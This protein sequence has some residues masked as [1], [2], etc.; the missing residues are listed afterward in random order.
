MK[1]HTELLKLRTK[2]K[3]ITSEILEKLQLME[4]KRRYLVL[5]YSSLFDYLVRG[6]GY[7]GST[8]YERQSCL[9]LSREIPEIKEK[10]Q[11][12][13]LTYS[14]VTAAY[15]TLKKKSTTE[16]KVI[17]QRLENKSVREVKRLLA[18]PAKPIKIKKTHYQNKVI[19]RL[20][21]SHDQNEKL[22]RLKA[23][24]SHS[25][26]LEKLFAELIEKELRKYE[27]TD[28][29]QSKSTNPRVVS[30]RLKNHL[31]DK[32]GGRC[33]YPGCEET[34]YLQIDHILPVR[35]GGKAKPENLQVLCGA[36]NR[37][38]S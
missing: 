18:E 23:L 34:H 3:Q 10:I 17:L 7:S 30:R 14:T 16:K 6:L 32:A 31:L 4:N 35:M 15:K 26:D 20:E 28:F 12:G 19:L 9:R 13:T 38:K 1:I 24:K 33:Q 25:G 36:H 37:M 21:M 2:E 22:E 27:V 5:G 11:A 8:A 29:K